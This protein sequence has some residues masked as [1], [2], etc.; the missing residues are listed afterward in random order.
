MLIAN[1]SIINQICGHN[2][3]GVTN[4]LKWVRP[5]V[6][7]GYYGYSDLGPNDAQI[8]RDSFPTG[9]N[10]PYSLVL[11]DKGALLSSTTTTNGVGT[12]TSSVALGRAISATL[13]GTTTLT[14]ANLALIVQVACS[15]LSQA[16]VT[17]SIAGRISLAATLAGQG[18]TTA[19][20]GL[21]SSIT[22]SLTSAS[23]ISGDLRGKLFMS[24]DLFVNQSE[25]TAEQIAAAVWNALATV[26]NN[27][28][29]MGELLNGAG[30]GSTPSQVADA[31]WD[32]LL[33]GHT[34]SG[35]TGK[36]LRDVLKT[37]DFIA[38]K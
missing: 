4:P 10:P 28:D 32:E 21:I 19:A 15:L 14:N 35:S 3:S 7:R 12:F 23:T 13:E 26:Y 18:N 8:K 11:G 17:A 1:Y 16:T 6:M 33:S 31:V 9:T 2:H 24:A 25:A 27:P 5:H 38:L 34:I 29:T 36:K 20:L 22:A 37:G 30:G